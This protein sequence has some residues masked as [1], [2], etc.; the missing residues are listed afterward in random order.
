MRYAAWV[1]IAALGAG[2]LWLFWQVIE[3]MVFVYTLFYGR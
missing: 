3:L 2:L 1:L